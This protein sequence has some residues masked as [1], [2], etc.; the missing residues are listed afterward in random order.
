M[1]DFCDVL[2]LYRGLR[3]SL[4]KLILKLQGK[5]PLF[6]QGHYLHLIMCLHLS[7]CVLIMHCLF[8]PHSHGILV[9]SSTGVPC[10][11]DDGSPSGVYQRCCWDFRLTG[12]VSFWG[13]PS[14]CPRSIRQGLVRQLPKWSAEFSFSNCRMGDTLKLEVWDKDLNID[15]HLFTCVRKVARR[16]ED[17]TCSTSSGTLYYTYKVY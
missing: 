11:A 17:V 16:N 7:I 6:N 3:L 9:Q 15:D 1:K 13:H 5:N 10:H 12:Q 8:F 4:S 14:E 2:A